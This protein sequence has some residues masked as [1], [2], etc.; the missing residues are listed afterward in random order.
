MVWFLRGIKK[1]S[2]FKSSK[3]MLSQ[4]ILIN[5]HL[6]IRSFYHNIDHNTVNYLLALTT[7][8][9]VTEKIIEPECL[10]LL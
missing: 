3:K 6:I 1:H 7:L 5:L 10:Q 2:A 8:N 4:G 9:L